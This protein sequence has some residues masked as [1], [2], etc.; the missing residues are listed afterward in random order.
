VRALRRFLP[1]IPVVLASGRVDEA[2]SD[3]LRKLGV[4]VRLDKPFTEAQLAQALRAALA[5]H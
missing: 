2:S 4:V 3:E 5:A 1:D